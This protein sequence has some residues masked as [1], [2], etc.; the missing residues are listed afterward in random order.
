MLIRF[1]QIDYDREMAFIAV[2]EEDGK[3]IEIGVARYTTNPDGE[4]C[5]FAIVVADAWQGRGIGSQLMTS[6]IQ[7]ARRRRYKRMDGEVLRENAHMLRMME[8]L[9]FTREVEVE[10]D[11]VVL[12]TK[13]L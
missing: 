4:T 6:L 8:R 2:A 7:S 12:V 10:D 9:G 5:E 3:E 13:A 11:T 1:T